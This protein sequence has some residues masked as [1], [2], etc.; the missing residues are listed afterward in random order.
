MALR[1]EP[2]PGDGAGL[3]AILL[4]VARKRDFLELVYQSKG[5]LP[6]GVSGTEL[7]GI[8]ER[9]PWR[10]FATPRETDSKRFS[11][12]TRVE[13]LDLEGIWRAIDVRLSA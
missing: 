5:G 10:L 12:R 9:L 11:T 7:E 4:V 3:D 13:D 8:V 1:S 2:K 6:P